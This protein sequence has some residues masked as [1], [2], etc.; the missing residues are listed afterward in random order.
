MLEVAD[1]YERLDVINRAII[2]ALAENGKDIDNL[3]GELPKRARMRDKAESA[4]SA[5]SADAWLSM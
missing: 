4:E 1:Y 3:L 2:N 5:S